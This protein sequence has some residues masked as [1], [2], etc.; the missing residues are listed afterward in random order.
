MIQLSRIKEKSGPPKR[1]FRA[2]FVAPIE[3]IDASQ[4]QELAL[5]TTAYAGEEM[6]PWETRHDK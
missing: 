6:R 1:I 5:H 4:C 3:Q 2:R